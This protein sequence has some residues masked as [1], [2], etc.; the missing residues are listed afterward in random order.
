MVIDSK[1]IFNR[2]YIFSRL[3]YT[4]QRMKIGASVQLVPF[5]CDFGKHY[6]ENFRMF[7]IPEHESTAMMSVSLRQE[8]N[9][10]L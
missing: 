10:H 7:P 6:A 5:I 9:L 2:E 8:E 1:L 3:T 4:A